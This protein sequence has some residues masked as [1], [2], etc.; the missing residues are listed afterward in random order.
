MSSILNQ[1]FKRQCKPTQGGHSLAMP[2]WPWWPF[3]CGTCAPA[4]Y[5]D[6]A[7]RV[8]QRFP[9]KTQS[10]NLYKMQGQV[11]HRKGHQGR[12]GMAK[13]GPSCAIPCKEPKEGR[14]RRNPVQKNSEL[15]ADSLR[16]SGP[17]QVSPHMGRSELLKKGRLA[18]ENPD[19]LKSS[20]LK[21][22]RRFLRSGSIMGFFFGMF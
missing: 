9:T 8:L 5:R 1:H 10:P 6:L 19:S 4:F 15:A 16:S 14:K 21:Q 11:S 22:V 20:A 7:W 17:P 18:R 13:K 2:A 3:L 12:A